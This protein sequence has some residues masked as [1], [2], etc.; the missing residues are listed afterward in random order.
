MSKNGAASEERFDIQFMR[1]HAVDD[2]LVDAN[3]TFTARICSAYSADSLVLAGRDYVHRGINIAKTGDVV[4][5]GM[6]SRAFG[7][8][9]LRRN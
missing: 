1:R 2:G 4:K 5:T 6:R 3:T 8:D 7:S 9:L